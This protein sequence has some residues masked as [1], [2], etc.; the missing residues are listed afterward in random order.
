MKPSPFLQDD[1][2][3]KPDK[4][5]TVVLYLPFALMVCLYTGFALYQLQNL[6]Y[7][8]QQIGLAVAA[9]AVLLAAG[10]GLVRLYARRPRVAVVLLLLVAAGLRLCF[11]L[12]LPTAPMS[13]FQ[14]FYQAAE[15]MRT[16]SLAWTHVYTSDD[17]FYRWA[18]QIPFTLY[19]AGILSICPSIV[20]VKLADVLWMTLS[21]F[22]VYRIASRFTASPWAIWFA[23]VYAVDPS[24]IYLVNMMSNQPVSTF[25]LLWG[26]YTL[27]S[28]KRW[29]GFALAGALLGLHQLMR[30]EGIIALLAIGACCVYRII[31]SPHRALLLRTAGQ[32]AL[33]VGCYLLVTMGTEQLLIATDVAPNGIGNLRPE[34][35]FAIGLN[36]ASH[37]GEY[38]NDS[39]YIYRIDDAGQRKQA[40]R[41]FIAQ[42]YQQCDK[43]L[44]FFLRKISC[45][46]TDASPYFWLLNGV[47]QPN[48][49]F[50]LTA[51]TLYPVLSTL[52]LC[53]RAF[54]YGFSWIALIL[55][56]VR[57]QIRPLA[58]NPAALLCMAI[59]GCAFCAFLILEVQPKYRYYVLP[60]LYCLAAL[61]AFKK[62][63]AD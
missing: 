4:W 39:A 29:Y 45:Y 21:V 26:L 47:D 46:W 18:Y 9:L 12:S 11:A 14:A 58:Q 25:L 63:Q 42:R 56:L 30:P 17:Y 13:D 48:P 19:E 34:H 44:S 43:P 61:L 2:S 32:L 31:L 1:R 57:R 24:A 49:P 55:R 51:E 35:R 62:P 53:L 37:H 23:F 5:Q 40:L 10:Y 20:A 28:S 27:L 22:L 54:L 38:N 52:E 36:F 15:E 41:Q 7:N 6:I 8:G 3:L 60:F 33:V 59:L 50:G 16:G